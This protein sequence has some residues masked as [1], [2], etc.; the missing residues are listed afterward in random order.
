M[1]GSSGYHN[2]G[3]KG[4]NMSEEKIIRHCSPTLAGIKTGNMFSHFYKNK[5]EMHEDL[6]KFNKSLCRKGLCALPLR[7]ENNR[8]LIYIYRPARLSCDLKNSTACRILRERGYETEAPARCGAELRRRV[9]A[10]DE[11]PHEIGLFLGYPPEDVCGFIEN[12]EDDCKCVGAW[13]VYGDKK[14]AEELFE[15]Y[16]KCT[17]VYCEQHSKGRSIERLTVSY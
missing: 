2:S 14:K 13:K 5:K 16:K 7:F 17:A 4:E 11:F 1:H 10:C 8:A 9:S 12:R 15:K 3:R 6:R